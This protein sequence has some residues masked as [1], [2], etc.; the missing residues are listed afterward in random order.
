MIITSAC[1]DVGVCVSVRHKYI[2][3]THTP[4]AAKWSI[5]NHKTLITLIIFILVEKDLANIN[6]LLACLCFRTSLMGEKNNVRM[7]GT[8][9]PK[10]WPKVMTG[11]ESES[12]VDFNQ[13]IILR[14]WVS[15]GERWLTYPPRSNN[16]VR[17]LPVSGNYSDFP[18]S[19]LQNPAGSADRNYW[20]GHTHTLSK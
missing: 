16:P 5:A 2:I 1:V 9:W 12:E 7:K 10:T 19:F 6:Y 8:I 4:S 20:P 15:L 17:K 13:S 18:A 3:H 14:V 11:G